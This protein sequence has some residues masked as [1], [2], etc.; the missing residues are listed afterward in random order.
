MRTILI[1]GFLGSGKT[2]TLLNLATYLARKDGPQ[3]VVILENE[4]GETSAG[5]PNVGQ[6]PFFTKDLSRGCI[7]CTSMY[8]DMNDTLDEIQSRLHPSFLL[9]ETSALSHQT[10]LDIIHQAL[11]PEIE[12]YC[13][14]LINAREG[15]YP[16]EGNFP[17]FANLVEKASLVLVN[18][19]EGLGQDELDKVT[20]QIVELNPSCRLQIVNAVQ[21]DLDDLWEPL[22]NP[23]PPL[24]PEASA[25]LSY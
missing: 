16:E 9:I 17:L 21:D 23:P 6:T 8:G 1:S 25:T 12:P 13:V 10:I 7:G 5:C 22:W 14:L 18:K 4:I 11:R 19:V 24:E 20:S 2:S 3:S 15:P